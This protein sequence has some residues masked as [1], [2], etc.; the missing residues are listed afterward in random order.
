[1]ESVV[2]IIAD[3][4]GYTRFMTKTKMSLAHAQ[5][6]ITELLQSILHEIE[7]PLHVV[8]IEGDAVF[9]Y[10]IEEPG[11]YGWEETIALT[12]R[13]LLIFFA[14]FYQRLKQL[15]RSNMCHCNA[16]RRV[17]DLRL[18]LIVHVGEAVFYHIANF[19]KL[20]GPDVILVHRLLK[21]SIRGSEY[22]LM[23]ESTYEAMR[24]HQAFEVEK[25]TET[26]DELGHVTVYVHYPYLAEM[27]FAEEGTISFVQKLKETLTVVT[28]GM[29][30]RL[31]LRTPPEM[32]N[33]S[34]CTEPSGQD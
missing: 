10:G 30:F 32:Q 7:I 13:K 11:V 31:G 19:S 25:T 12:S 33:I 34:G 16:C 20:S 5:A 4:S 8:E 27:T 26:Y 6:I 2:L 3:I 15:Q 24:Q 1:M 9:F 23:T 28:K 14:S 29:A 17:A 18:K 22:L 21:N